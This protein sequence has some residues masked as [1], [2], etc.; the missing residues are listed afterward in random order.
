MLS[1]FNIGDVI[2]TIAKAGSLFNSSAGFPPTL[3]MAA[4]IAHYIGV[5]VGSN[6]ARA[7]VIDHEGNLLAIATQ[8]TQ[9]WQSR[10]GC[11]VRRK[12]STKAEV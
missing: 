1:N 9:T 10:P 12:T 8:D 3:V 5:D 7:C 6:S 11:Y 2:C 4:N